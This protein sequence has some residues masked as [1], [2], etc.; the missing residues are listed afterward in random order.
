M[1]DVT[2]RTSEF[3]RDERGPEMRPVDP[4]ERRLLEAMADGSWDD[5]PGAGR[6][7]P[8]ID[9]DYE[10]GWWARRWVEMQRR[11]DA[12]DTLRRLIREE[13]PRLQVSRDRATAQRRVDELNQLV[14]D[15]NRGLPEG[16]QVSPVQL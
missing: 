8:D 16:E 6:P 4:I 12:A 11:S 10:P 1:S 3:E 14:A 7:L 5:L 15:V 2:P 13:L 9:R